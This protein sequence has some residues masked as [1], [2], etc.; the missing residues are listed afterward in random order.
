MGSPQANIYLG[1]PLVAAVAALTGIID[2]PRAYLE[3]SDSEL[4]ALVA[5]R[6]AERG[7][8]GAASSRS[9]DRLEA[10]QLA[11]APLHISMQAA[12]VDD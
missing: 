1:S 2:D 4:D 12:E 9:G 3:A 7:A 8:R 10:L 11:A 6:R 5:R